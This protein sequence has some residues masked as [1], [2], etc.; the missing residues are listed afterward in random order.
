MI[1]AARALHAILAIVS[2]TEL[3]E[4]FLPLLRAFGRRHLRDSAA[5]EE[6]AQES[7]FVA[8][9]ALREGRVDHDAFGPYTLGVA[10]N[11]VREGHRAERRRRTLDVTLAPLIDVELP[12]TATFDQHLRLCVSK[13]TPTAREVLRRAVVEEEEGPEIAAA[14]GI[15]A[16]NVR[17]T[18]HRALAEVRKCLQAGEA[19]P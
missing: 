19:S 7:L 16:N 10:R 15:T 13:L 17:V 3:C 18:R 5:A 12:P 8:L 11:L 2:E 9:T 14:L 1:E 4:A 6:L